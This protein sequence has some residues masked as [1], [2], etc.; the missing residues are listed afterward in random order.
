MLSDKVAGGSFNSMSYTLFDTLLWRALSPKINSWRKRTLNLDQLV[1]KD[2]HKI[3]TINCF[4]PTLIPPPS[5][6]PDW[7]HIW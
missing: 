6:W 3:P 5:D 4:D 1:I 7:V 2:D